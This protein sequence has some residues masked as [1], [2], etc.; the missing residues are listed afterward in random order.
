[1]SRDDMF[2]VVAREIAAMLYSNSRI[3]VNE[4]TPRI[5][6]ALIKDDRFPTEQERQCLAYGDQDDKTV[7]GVTAV[8]P[9]RSQA[10][11]SFF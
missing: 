7:D 4:S 5:Q 1:M 9:N 2:K 6:A 3:S 10:I 11:D 8:F